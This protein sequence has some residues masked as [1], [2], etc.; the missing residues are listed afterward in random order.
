MK[1]TTAMRVMLLGVLIYATGVSATTPPTA[2]TI[3]VVA[4]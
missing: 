2:P 1:S 4:V 3:E